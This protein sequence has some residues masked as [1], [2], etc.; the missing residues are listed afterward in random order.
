MSSDGFATLTLSA[1]EVLVHT[2]SHSITNNILPSLKA[3]LRTVPS[4][5]KDSGAA[6]LPCA[7][8]HFPIPILALLIHSRFFEP[9]SHLLVSHRDLQE[10]GRKVLSCEAQ[11]LE[12]PGWW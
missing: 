11:W 3:S 1:L 12:Q 5:L 9:Q 8:P 10:E 4:R 2:V 6:S 7:K